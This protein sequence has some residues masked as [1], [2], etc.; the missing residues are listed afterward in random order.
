MTAREWCEKLLS[1]GLLVKQTHEFTVR[2]S[3]P[4]VIGKSHVD[5]ALDSIKNSL[6]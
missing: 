6:V 5:E 2:M 3:P 4:L 1:A